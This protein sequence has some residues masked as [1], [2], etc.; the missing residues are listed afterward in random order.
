MIEKFVGNS[1]ETIGKNAFECSYFLKEINLKNVK[2]IGR[3][4]F[5]ETALK[6]IKND[7]IKELYNY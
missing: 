4:A 2:E 3:C 7:H 6:I 5:Q 1:L